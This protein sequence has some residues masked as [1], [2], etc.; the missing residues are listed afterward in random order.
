MNEQPPTPPGAAPAGRAGT[1]VAGAARGAGAK[2]PADHAAEPAWAVTVV[3]PTAAAT[4]EWGRDLAGLLRAGDLLV[5]SGGLGAGKTTLTQG[6]GAG[7]QV[8]GRIASP[9]FIIARSHPAAGQG[10]ALVHVD[11]YRLTSLAEVDDLD[12]DA[13]MTESV[14]VVEWGAGMVE[15]L[16]ADRLEIELVRARGAAPPGAL[17]GGRPEPVAGPDTGG[18]TEAASR[19][20]AQA[21]SAP[22]LGTVPQAEPRTATVR[23]YGPR[24]SGIDITEVAQ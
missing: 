12:L 17:P 5:L 16:A 18:A 15:D 8:G 21:Q 7:L 1:D 6:I 24:W 22:G 14:T 20:D 2:A 4:I 13:S 9:T 19:P 10:P 23:G 3:L 11:A